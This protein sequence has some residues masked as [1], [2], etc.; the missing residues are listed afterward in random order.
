MRDILS[1]LEA[2]PTLSDPDPVRRAQIQMKAPLPKRFYEKAAV[3]EAEGGFTVQLDGKLVR[4]PAR[5][6]LLLPT[7]AAAQ[8]VADEF[9]AQ[10]E[11]VN[12]ET[13][14]VTRLVNTAIDGIALDHQAVFEDILRFASCDM[15]FYRADSPQELVDRQTKQWDPIIDW[16][17]SLG[18][19]FNLAEGVMHV[20]QPRE[21]IAAY[22]A[23]LSSANDPFTLAVLHTFTTLTGSALLALAVYKQ[24]LTAEEAWKLAHLDED[25][26]IENWGEDE[27]AHWRRQKRATEMFATDA[28][29]K[30]IS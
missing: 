13:M 9:E 11:V 19:R 15:L 29:L 10:K 3:V 28:L 6:P 16:A 8:L 23:H 27:E 14:P 12:A 17:Q 2:G 4:T 7:R 30:A 21:A 18:A 5:Q 24:H 20:E 22:G 25:W 1:D 26:T